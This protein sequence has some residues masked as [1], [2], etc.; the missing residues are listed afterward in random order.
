MEEKNNLDWKLYEDI[1]KFIYETLGKKYNVHI[2]G[3]GRNCKITGA[4][5]VTHQIDVLT[6]ESDGINNYKTAIECKYLKKKVDKDIVMKLLSIINDT[7]IQRGIIVSKSGF[8]PDAKKFAEHYNIK[9]VQLREIS[10]KDQN[11]KKEIELGDIDLYIHTI[12]KRPIITKIVARTKEHNDIILC[13]QDQYHILIENKNGN[14][15]KLFDAIMIFKKFLHNQSPFEMIS[16]IDE[17]PNYRLHILGESYEITKIV[18]TGLLT[19]QDK[20]HL[21]MFSLINHVWLIMQ[22]I[23]ENQTFVISDYGIIV[24]TSI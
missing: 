3:Y 9:I 6:S 7:D 16:K 1:T 4:S 24:N 5:G 10:E 12:L 15:M 20:H 11:I 17:Y 13:E 2:E 19:V 21:T 23:F 8:T 22:Q 14:Q 18:F